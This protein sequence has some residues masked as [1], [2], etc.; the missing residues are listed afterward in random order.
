MHACFSAKADG[1]RA[2]DGDDPWLCTASSL[3]AGAF[4][5]DRSTSPLVGEGLARRHIFAANIGNAL[6]FYDFITY[7]FFSIQIGH[8]F[9]P[10]KDAFA[11]LMLSLATFGAGF[12]TRPLGGFLIGGYADRVGRK[13][14]MILSFNLMG[15]AIVALALTPTYA[16]IGIA[17]PILAVTA[18]MIQ[19]FAMGGEVGPNTAYLVEAAAPKQRGQVVAWQGGSQQ[20]A[21]I[22][23]S[24]VGLGL[25]TVM[26]GPALDAYGWRIAFLLGA[27]TLPFGLWLRHALPETLNS[28]EPARLQAEP[29]DVAGRGRARI[30][31]LGLA[32]L[33]S[34][35][36]GT[37]VINY[38][39]TF[40]RAAL[41]M[42]ATIAF[43]ATLAPNFA[44][45]VGVLFGG[46]LSDRMGRR[47]VMIWPK[48][49]SLLVVLP[50][51]HW[52]VTAHSVIALLGGVSFV[53]FL[54]SVAN[55]AF[56]PAFCES[57][58]KRVRGRAFGTVY[59]VAIAV[60]GG[61]TQLI[62]TWLIHVTGD[63]GAPG[64]YWLAAS[65]LG[66]VAMT[67]MTESA[68]VRAEARLALQPS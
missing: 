48:L 12:A 29:R 57:L 58:S 63:K 14:A 36:I 4:V 40:A 20:L 55:G 24:L 30:L 16:A 41:H 52:I 46:W 32:V 59:A 10:S 23:G 38:M 64:W 33:A 26:S 42:P 51:F 9:F 21:A 39:N 6:E 66:F 7:A 67:L 47:P 11:S 62:V 37:Y 17:A 56:Y 5:Q 60:F 68:P 15:V 45:L 54:S 18:R 44:G 34:G 2:V 28:P 65:L 61:T 22:A 25:S 43:A 53:A 13:A 35:T 31:I 50:V 19:G 27:G 8:A 49:A 3:A 1:K